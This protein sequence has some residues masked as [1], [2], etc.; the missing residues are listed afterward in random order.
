[1]GAAI[2]E[3]IGEEFDGVCVTL[4]QTGRLG[5][6]PRTV[7][8]LLIRRAAKQTHGTFES[9][10]GEIRRTAGKTRRTFTDQRLEHRR[11][12]LRCVGNEP[13][14]DFVTGDHPSDRH[15]PT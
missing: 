13:V 7:R 9:I 15:P 5:T 1:M 6:R 10:G 3:R 2:E 4:A 8:K 14:A 11:I 12:D